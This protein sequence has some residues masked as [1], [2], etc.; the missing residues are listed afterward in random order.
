MTRG[1][2]IVV[3]GWAGASNPLPHPNP[4]P[5]L[6]LTQKASETRVFPLINSMTLDGPTDEPSDG[7]SLL[8]SYVSGTKKILQ[9]SIHMMIYSRRC[10][11]FVVI[12]EP[13]SLEFYHKSSS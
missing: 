5:T 6:K 2:N 12:A 1:H 4:P 3:V 8:Q 10:T 11:K 9:I 7:Q 13:E